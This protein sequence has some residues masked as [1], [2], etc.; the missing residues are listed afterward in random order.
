MLKKLIKNN[1]LKCLILIALLLASCLTTIATN[2][3]FAL[4]NNEQTDSNQLNNLKLSSG[5]TQYYELVSEDINSLKE[6]VTLGISKTAYELKKQ[7]LQ[8]LP[9][10]EQRHLINS[11]MN[12]LH[13]EVLDIENWD[14]CNIDNYTKHTYDEEWMKQFTQDAIINILTKAVNLT[15]IDTNYSEYN[16]VYEKI[17]TLK[18]I[19]SLAINTLRSLW[20]SSH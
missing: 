10:T 13:E 18:T 19:P 3:V 9:S 5:T 14:D 4:K 16:T 1:Y 7:L 2:K 15:K 12:K 20:F 6:K 11:Y 8:A 17:T